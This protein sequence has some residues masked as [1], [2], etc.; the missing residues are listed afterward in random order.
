[1]PHNKEYDGEGM[2]SAETERLIE[3]YRFLIEEMAEGYCELDLAGTSLLSNKSYLQFIGYT[4]DEFYGMNY[5]E[6]MEEDVAKKVYHVFN[7]V[8]KTGIPNKSFEYEIVTRD[9]KKRTQ[10]LSICLRIGNGGVPT[11]FR[12][13]VR[14]ITEKREALQTLAKQRSHLEA[15]FS[16]VQDAIVTFDNNLQIL[17]AN[18]AAER[19]CGIGCGNEAKPAFNE[20][21]QQ[22]SMGC[23]EVLK[24]TLQK[25]I[26][27]KDYR[28][29][30]EHSKRHSQTVKVSSSPLV[31]KG[32]EFIGV[33]LVIRDITR[34][35][36]LETQLRASYSFQNIVGKSI[37]MQRIFNLLVRLTNI[38]TT[39]LIQGESGTGKELA[40]KA[41]H[42]GGSRAFKPFIIVNCSA[43]PETLLESELFGHVK[44]AFTGAVRDRQGRFQAADGGTILLDEIGDISPMV[45]LKLLRVLEGKEFEK[46]GDHKPI[47]VN[48]RVIA[49]TNKDLQLMVK[50]GAFRSDLY[51]RLK[52]VEVLLPPLRER[53]DDIPIL[54]EHFCKKLNTSHSKKIIGV[55]EEVLFTFM[56]YDWPGNV[57][58]LEHIIER[59]FILCNEEYISLNHL[60]KDLLKY[61][62][63]EN[64][65]GGEEKILEA[66]ERTDGNKAKAARLLGMSRRTIYRKMQKYSLQSS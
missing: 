60:P 13:I 12:C 10:E 33:V 57:R 40:A 22:C 43:L 29:E 58:E 46:V 64:K 63:V 38:D 66:L 9:G 62:Q 25:K 50:Q 49:S 54:V 56:N 2:P 26:S 52:V 24:Y 37:T 1:M 45:Q 28:I 39:V 3:A 51:Y 41:I 65:K 34:L 17:E 20:S 47:K 5:R 61:H 53:L 18:E 32:N 55:S 6:Y 7:K 8:Y 30:C 27:I 35:D 21:R 15:I 31:S 11:G 14:D 59:G 48:V 23:V 4:E 36:H 44:G 19:I 16:S 42:F